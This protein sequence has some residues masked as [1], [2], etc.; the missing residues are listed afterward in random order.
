MLIL[1]FIWI[2]IIDIN[3]SY[4]MQVSENYSWSVWN[5]TC[6]INWLFVSVVTKP[7]LY[8]MF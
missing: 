5:E 7:D 3:K 6:I 1:S 8:S 2:K 4:L